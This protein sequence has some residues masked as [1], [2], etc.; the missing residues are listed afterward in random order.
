MKT[1]CLNPNCPEYYRYGGRGIG[2]CEKWKNSF[3][4]FRDWA[5]QTGYKED[6]EIHR[7]N[8]NLGYFPEN[9]EWLTKSEHMR[10]HNQLRKSQKE[11]RNNE[12]ISTA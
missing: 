10:W 3:I 5:Y 4:V 8:N 12:Q 1:R 9:C 2:I 6:L 7:K 11:L